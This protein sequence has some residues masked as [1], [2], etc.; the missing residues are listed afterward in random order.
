[1]T[2]N[3]QCSKNKPSQ[4]W[5]NFRL[6]TGMFGDHLIMYLHA[7]W[8]SYRYDMPLHCTYEEFPFVTHLKLFEKEI[9]YNRVQH[10]NPKVCLSREHPLPNREGSVEYTVPYFPEVQWE[11]DSGDGT[12]YHLF[13]VDWKDPEFRRQALEMIS[14]RY[15]L[16]L[17]LPPK[18]KISIA[19][20][21]RRGGAYEDRETA[22]FQNPMKFPPLTYYAEGLFRLYKCFRENRSIVMFLLMNNNQQ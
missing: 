20:H 14:P 5:V 16:S 22:Q 10:T 11:Y 19:V 12:Y 3:I 4:S 18:D 6:H 7:K 1:M 9:D 15:P 21:V 2:E 13:D 17:V 8:L